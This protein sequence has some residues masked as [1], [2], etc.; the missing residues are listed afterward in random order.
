[1]KEWK[2]RKYMWIRYGE[3]LNFTN[4]LMQIIAS[5]MDDNKREVVH[6][7]LAPCTNEAFLKKYLELDPPFEFFLEEEL[8]IL[9]IK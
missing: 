1:M 9:Y 5:Y 2:R 8:G 3:K 4:E 6:A 7:E